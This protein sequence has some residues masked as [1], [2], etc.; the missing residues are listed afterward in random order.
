MVHGWVLCTHIIIT[1]GS[2]NVFWTDNSCW[3]NCGCITAKQLIN[4]TWVSVHQPCCYFTSTTSDQWCN[5]CS[6]WLRESFTHLTKRLCLTGSE[7]KVCVFLFDIRIRQIW[8]VDPAAELGPM[9]SDAKQN[10]ETDCETASL[11]KRV[12]ARSPLPNL[13]G[14]TWQG[15]EEGCR[16]DV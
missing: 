12:E 7:W 14:K 1:S 8:A 11:G 3:H 5:W 10:P 6:F 16:H 4:S 13:W 15:S 9:K 2:W